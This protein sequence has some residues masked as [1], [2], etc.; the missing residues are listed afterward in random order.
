MKIIIKSTNLELTEAIKNY[1]NKKTSSL[2][3]FL[4]KYEENSELNLNIEIA[5]TTRH[6]QKGDV[7][8]AEI[9]LKLPNKLL[10]AEE[11]SSNLYAAIDLVKDKIKEEILKFKSLNEKNKR[12]KK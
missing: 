1:I 11:Y 6:H 10:R 4:K 7:F 2:N 5:K 8:Y 9:N 3:R 12:N